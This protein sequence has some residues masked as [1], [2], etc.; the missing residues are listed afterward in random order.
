MKS[1]NRN[2]DG[3][4]SALY[5]PRVSLHNNS[6]PI[7]KQT[8]CTIYVLFNFTEEFRHSSAGVQPQQDPGEPSG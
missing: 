1:V 8:R 4:E 7:F 5:T 2:T 6:T 3:F